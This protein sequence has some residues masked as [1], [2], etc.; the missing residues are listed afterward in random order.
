MAEAGLAQRHQRVFLDP[1]PVSRLWVAYDPRRVANRLQIAGDD[2]VERRSFRAGDS[3]MP[4]RGTASAV[5]TMAAIFGAV[6]PAC[7]AGSRNN[8]G[9]LLKP[10]REVVENQSTVQ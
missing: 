1:A 7:E 9:N 10:D 6:P 2:F 3:T 4:L 8:F 5:S